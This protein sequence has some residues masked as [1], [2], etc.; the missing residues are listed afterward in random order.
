MNKLIIGLSLLM[1][2]IGIGV[3]L[4]AWFGVLAAGEPPVVVHLSTGALIFSGAGNVLT[5]LVN[6]E[7]KKN[8]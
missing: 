3:D 6:R 7:V 5:A 4:L 8:G 2:A 1:L